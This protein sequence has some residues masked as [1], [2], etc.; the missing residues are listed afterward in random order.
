M[1]QQFRET[2]IL[3]TEVFQKLNFYSES[4]F[5]VNNSVYINAN[6]IQIIFDN[7]TGS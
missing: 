1:L 6:V 4:I 3:F 7:K 5:F 2:I